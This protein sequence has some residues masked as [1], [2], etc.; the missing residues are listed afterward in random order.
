MF[1]DNQLPIINIY[2]S[3]HDRLEIHDAIRGVT[4]TLNTE[5]EHIS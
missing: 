3:I 4:P 5:G 2:Y 1:S